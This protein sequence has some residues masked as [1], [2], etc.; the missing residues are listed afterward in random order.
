MELAVR[1]LSPPDG[2]DNQEVLDD[3]LA[4]AVAND[5][6]QYLAHASPVADAT[7]FAI[8]LWVDDVYGIFGVGFGTEEWFT[9]WHPVSSPVATRPLEVLTGP[10]WRWMSG[11]WDLIAVPFLSDATERSLRPLSAVLND[12]DLPEDE[13]VA[14]S[15]RW[16]EIGFAAVSMLTVPPALNVTPDFLCYAENPDTH[17]VEIAECML[18]TT[19]PDRF[20]AA[21]PAWRA[22]AHAV[23]AARK[24]DDMMRRLRHLAENET[25]PEGRFPQLFDD[26]ALDNLTIRLNACNLSWWHVAT[27]AENLNR[28]LAVADR[29]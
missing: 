12:V 14:A 2:S 21:I 4:E 13:F 20:H 3:E 29:T 5:L 19:P 28:A 10:G 15:S 23:R 16:R 22:L 18:R 8:A 27:A 7:V 6:S 17:V 24:D 26:P 1:Q 11:N 25:Q 9:A